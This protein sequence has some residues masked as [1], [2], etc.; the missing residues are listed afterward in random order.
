VKWL[1]KFDEWVRQGP[2]TPQDLGLYRIIYSCC[3][4]LIVPDI[5][6]LAEYPDFMFHPPLGPFQLLSGFPSLAVLVGLEALRTVCLVLLGLGIWTRFVSIATAVVLV[7]TYGLTYC[8]GKIDHTVLLVATPLILSFANWG[9][10]L[11]VD[12][13][14]GKQPQPQPPRQWPLRLLGLAI[15]LPFFAAA[16]AKL[17]T[18]WLLWSSQAAQGQFFAGFDALGRTSW[19]APIAAQFNV[20]AAWEVLDWLTVIIEFALLATLPWWRAFRI[21]L[22]VTAIF[23]LGVFLVMNISFAHNIVVYGAFVPW[24]AR[25]PAARVLLFAPLIAAAVRLVVP[26]EVTA[27][28]IL[29]AGA[30]F[31]VG[32]LAGQLWSMRR[33]TGSEA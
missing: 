30:V 18:G 19:L 17:G 7:V 23:H 12:A 22:A 28:V 29:F 15:A 33:L 5:T 25:L 2:F 27:A 24:A 8:L 31:G 1:A 20:P 16:L 21:A 32:Y 14:R 26:A 13:L 9:D 3:A 6:W 4:L 11:S 10:R